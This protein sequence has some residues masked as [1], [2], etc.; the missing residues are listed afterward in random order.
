M[1]EKARVYK[2][3]ILNQ[4]KDN[5]SQ[6]KAQI[7]VERAFENLV[8]DANNEKLRE[9]EKRRAEKLNDQKQQFKDTWVNQMKMNQEKKEII[10]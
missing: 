6:V 2:D 4:I 8:V 7:E 10:V 9:E 3:S 5:Q 1:K